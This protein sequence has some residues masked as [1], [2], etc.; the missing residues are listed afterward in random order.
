[1][2]FL[3]LGLETLGN[4]INNGKCR[5]CGRPL[6]KNEWCNCQ[7]AQSLNRYYRKL[8][9]KIINAERQKLVNVQFA[10]VTIPIKFEGKTFADF[11]TTSPR[12][13]DIKTAVFDYA[14]KAFSNF[15]F[16][17]NLGL[18]GNYR[19]GKTLL[20]S[21]LV[22]KFEEDFSCKF[23]NMNELMQ[24]I[25]SSFDDNTST[26]K[27]IIAKYRTVDYL[28]MDDIDKVKPTEYTRE[29]MYAIV[30]YRT[31][32]ELPIIFAANNSL[33][34]L[35]AEYYGEAIIS[36]LADTEKSRIIRFNVENWVLKNVQ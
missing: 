21:I 7:K 4:R 15:L 8:N 2:D 22:Q 19:T 5:F 35:D 13:I 3:K 12:L 30:N 11:Q 28:F 36:R 10:P 34:I 23:I 33:E 9:N 25:K 20:M 26:V 32:N 1:M 24:E 29:V 27:S 14:E 16:G 17:K 6:Q 31:E 18:I